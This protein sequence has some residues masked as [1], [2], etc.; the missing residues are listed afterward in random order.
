[1]KKGKRSRKKQ[2]R[3]CIAM[4]VTGIVLVLW[5]TYG[6]MRYNDM[7]DS[8]IT[9]D[10]TSERASV[11]ASDRQNEALEVLLPGNRIVTIHNIK[12]NY[13]KG[14]QVLV[15]TDGQVATITTSHLM[16]KQMLSYIMILSGI[17]CLLNIPYVP[18][19]HK[20]YSFWSSKRTV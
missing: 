18:M 13:E 10:Y 6:M 11:V 12:G 15:A 14:E 4:I 20:E 9:E 17:I 3:N 8:I 5:G 16:L 2:L 19:Q 7:N 1:M